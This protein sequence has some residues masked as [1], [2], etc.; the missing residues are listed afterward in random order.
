MLIFYLLLV[1]FGL[2]IGSFLNV[3]IYRLPRGE[4]IVLPPSHCPQCEHRLTWLD[5]FPVLSFIFLQGRCR[6][7]R[8]KINRRYPLTELL[9]G[10]LTLLWWFHYGAYGLS[11]EN[12]AFL[13]LTYVLIAIAFIDWE[14]QIIPNRLTL[15]LIVLGLALAAL[16]G[17]LVPALVGALAGG[18]FLL[19]IALVYPKGMGFGDVKL[20]AMTGI[21]LGWRTVLISLF[22]GSVLGVLVTLPLLILKKINRKTSIAF[23]PF[24]AIGTLLIMYI[25]MPLYPW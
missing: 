10:G 12:I 8:A 4:S 16:Q 25:N 21:F 15:P 17:A 11:L 5:L 1:L 18:G 19:I 3:I 22:L 9:T 23:G 6:Y 24:L 14:Q 2:I 7:C 20:L 13:V